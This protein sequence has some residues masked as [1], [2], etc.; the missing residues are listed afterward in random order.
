MKDDHAKVIR[1]GYEVPLI[2]IPPEATEDKCDQCK[3]IFPIKNLH[4]G[5]KQEMLCSKCLSLIS[6]L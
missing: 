3:Q 4:L 5:A 1:D 6:D 2:G